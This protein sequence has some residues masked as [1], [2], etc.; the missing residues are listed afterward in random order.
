MTRK[1]YQLVASIIKSLN[2]GL[3]DKRLI[4]LQFADKLEKAN[5][6]FDRTKF[7]TLILRPVERS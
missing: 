4:A 2:C 1:D 7:L 5:S 6:S 3:G